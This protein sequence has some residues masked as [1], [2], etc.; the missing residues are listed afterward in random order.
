MQL[1]TLLKRPAITIEESTPM[2]VAWDLMRRHGI[3]YLPVLRDRALVGM[4][5]ERDLQRG[6]ASS[7]PEIRVHDW[8]ALL[9]RVTVGDLMTREPMA[10]ALATSVADAARLARSQRVDAFVVMD[11]G[12]IAGVVTRRDLLAVL[13]GLL[14]HRQPTGLGH[15]LVA[16]SLR[17]LPGGA[18]DEAARLAVAG[19]ALLTVLHVQTPIGWLAGVEGATSEQLVWVERARRR[20]A[21][22]AMAAVCRSGQ[23]QEVSCEVAEGPV[24]REIAR[25][26]AELDSDLIVVGRTIRHG[27][28]A[29]GGEMVV[30]QLARVAPCPVL[31][32]PRDTRSSHE[33]R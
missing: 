8:E 23:V 16:T 15:I 24:A 13:S 6:G 19:G 29:I 32:V 4:L 14:E 20:M 30:D 11:C 18:L 12:E 2:R 31:A 7:V 25:R 28:F 17:S 1:K 27:M 5:T 9:A 26:A 10:L 3:Q 33:G 22:E 21:D